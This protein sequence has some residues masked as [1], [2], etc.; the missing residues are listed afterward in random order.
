MYCLVHLEGA[1]MEGRP[2]P[3]FRMGCPGTYRLPVWDFSSSEGDPPVDLRL[4]NP[5][6]RMFLVPHEVGRSESTYSFLGVQSEYSGLASECTYKVSFP[7]DLFEGCVCLRTGEGAGITAGRA[8][9]G[10]HA[11]VCFLCFLLG[12]VFAYRASP[13]RARAAPHAY[14]RAGR[15]AAQAVGGRSA[16]SR[17]TP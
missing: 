2:W 7:E 17:R 15:R 6:P 14:A 4:L 5:P 8:L 16:Y 12:G 10:P 1:K 13:P 9:N 3:T 11:P